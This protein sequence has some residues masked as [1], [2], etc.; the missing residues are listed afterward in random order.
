MLFTYRAKKG[1]KVRKLELTTI[2]L[3]F[4]TQILELFQESGK[5]LKELCLKGC[6]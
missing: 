2:V 6:H 5:Q 4:F 1:R 3:D